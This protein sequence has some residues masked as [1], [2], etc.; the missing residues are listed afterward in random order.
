MLIKAI[1]APPQFKKSFFELVDPSLEFKQAVEVESKKA[2]SSNLAQVE[3]LKDK[4]NGL[5][6]E[7][8]SLQ[9]DQEEL[10]SVNMDLEKRVKQGSESLPS[11]KTVT[12]DKSEKTTMTHEEMLK[13]QQTLLLETAEYVK[14]TEFV[15]H[16]DGNAGDEYND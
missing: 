16:D 5:T 14:V 9:K 4:I 1:I 3:K 2:L 8:G 6:K 13:Q 15:L 10:K 11:S 7:V 12:S